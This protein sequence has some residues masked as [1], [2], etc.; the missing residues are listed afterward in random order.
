MKKLKKIAFVVFSMICVFGLFMGPL[1][2]YDSSSFYGEFYEL[3]ESGTKTTAVIDKKFEDPGYRL[4]HTF[5]KIHFTDEQSGKK[6]SIDKIRLGNGYF[7]RL[8]VGSRVDIYYKGKKAVLIDNYKSEYVPPSQTKYVG[9]IHTLISYTFIIGM[10]IR[11]RKK[12]K[13]KEQQKQ[14]VV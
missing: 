4:R 1:S 14:K 11:T 10:I 12:H 8:K 7:N 6:V 5:V 13:Q 9:M 3:K 2:W